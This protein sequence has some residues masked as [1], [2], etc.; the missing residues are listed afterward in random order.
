MGR[1]VSNLNEDELG[2]LSNAV[3]KMWEKYLQMDKE[4]YSQYLSEDV[5]RMSQRTRKLQDGKK[6]VL[7]GLQKEWEAFERPDN[8][9]S[10]EMTQKGVNFPLIGAVNDKQG[11]DIQ[12]GYKQVVSTDSEGNLVIFSEYSGKRK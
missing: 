3:K 5:R 8:V 2:S 12:P 6:A 10:E 4:G 9:I 11:I 7:F 1:R